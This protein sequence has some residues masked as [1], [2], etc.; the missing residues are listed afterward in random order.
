MDATQ[1]PESNAPIPCSWHKAFRNPVSAP[2]SRCT[3][4]LL[5]HGQV[6]I[7][8]PNIWPLMVADSEYSVHG[9]IDSGSRVQ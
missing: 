7:V 4:L 8:H 3:K 9:L 6:L 1:G 5:Q 2:H